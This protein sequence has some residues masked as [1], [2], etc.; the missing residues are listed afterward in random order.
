MKTIVEINGTKYV[1]VPQKYSDENWMPA[2]DLCAAARKIDDF[3]ISCSVARDWKCSEYDTLSFAV[4]L[5]LATPK[6]G[7]NTPS[8]AR[9]EA[10]G[11]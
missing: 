4:H 9:R 1:V 3:A 2:C 7:L 5:E 6:I 10:A 8:E 11:K